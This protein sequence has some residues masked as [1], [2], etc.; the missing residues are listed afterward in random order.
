VSSWRPC[1]GVAAAR[2]RAALLER[3]RA[4]FTAT[5]VLAVD[6]PVLARYAA[7][8]PHIDSLTAQSSSGGYF[9]HT[10]PEF[11][12]KRL[13]AAGF[14]DIY[15]IC[16]VF[17]DG[18]AGVRHAPEFTM[19]EWYRLGFSL[20]TIVE[21]TLR[22]IA[23]CLNDPALAGRAEIIDYGE[24]FL[25]HAGLDAF[26]AGVDELAETTTADDRLRREIGDERDVWLDLVMSTVVAPRLPADRLTVIRHYPASQAALAR[27]C[28]ADARVAD[29]F[30]VFSGSKEL[31][32]GYVELTD[33]ATQRK[34]FDVDLDM[35]QRL[36]RE[37]VP[38]DRHLVEALRAGL[39]ECAGVAVG[40]ERLQMVM[41]GTDDIRDVI[42]FESEAF[43]SE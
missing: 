37:A 10:S 9:M 38:W 23:Q 34:R 27:L 12:M 31:A 33:A 1:S 25:R 8:D 42:A 36:G 40:V 16:R 7:T 17:R 35:R 39:P 20:G 43:E 19:I 15:S 28:P 6:T 26:G 24:A 14:P 41:D 2:S 30:E 29:R 21:D 32:N 11:C 3:A 5:G 18:E 22:L 13:L 4:H